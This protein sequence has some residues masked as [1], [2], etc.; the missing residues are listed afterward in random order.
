MSPSNVYLR[1]AGSSCV[2]LTF[3][4][5]LHQARVRW[6]PMFVKES[7]LVQNG[8]PA[9]KELV[10]PFQLLDLSPELRN[11][12]YGLIVENFKH[13]GNE[14][15]YTSRVQ[16]VFKQQPRAIRDTLLTCKTVWCEL[17][18][19]LLG[20]YIWVADLRPQDFGHMN[21]YP[22]GNWLQRPSTFSQPVSN[23][24]RHNVPHGQSDHTG[25]RITLPRSHQNSL[26]IRNVST[27][28]QSRTF[29]RNSITDC[30]LRS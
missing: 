20:S 18:P 10:K 8:Y 11:I 1:V 15:R 30:A 24:I 23:Y 5:L 6:L 29:K 16:Y 21:I 7:E 19:L 25:S 12:I 14:K 22:G 3:A 26:S 17:L 13:K 28:M 27:M 2:T 9:V 4:Y